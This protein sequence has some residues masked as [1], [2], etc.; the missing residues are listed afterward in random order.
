VNLGVARAIGVDDQLS[1]WRWRTS[2]WRRWIRCST[3][4]QDLLPLSS[5]IV[6]GAILAVENAKLR[7]QFALRACFVNHRTRDEDVDAVVQEVL[8]AAAGVQ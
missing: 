5:R 6:I 1:Y 8:A 3:S 2:R 4:A 7:C